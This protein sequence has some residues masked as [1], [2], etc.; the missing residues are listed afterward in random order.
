MTQNSFLFVDEGLSMKAY[1]F[2]AG[3]VTIFPLWLFN[4]AVKNL[5]LGSVGF[6][7]YLRPSGI[8]C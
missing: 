3:V 4:N 5:E 7:Q 2:L 8:V 6:L 1:V